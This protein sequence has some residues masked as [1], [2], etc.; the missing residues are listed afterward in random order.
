MRPRVVHVP[1]HLLSTSNAKTLKGE[2]LGYSTAILHLAP[3]TRSGVANVCAYATPGCI[4]ACLDSTGRLRQVQ[5]LNARMQRTQFLKFDRHG[6]V[7]MLVQEI[8]AHERRAARAGFAPA[9]R[10]NGLS[11]IPWENMPAAG[12]R[13][14][15]AAFPEC[16]FYDYTKFPIRL[17]RRAL[18][19]PNY[20]LTFSLSDGNEQ[21]ARQALAAGVN[22]AAIFPPTGELPATFWGLPVINGDES[23]LRFN[24]PSPCIVG[25]RAKGTR[26]RKTSGFVQRQEEHDGAED[27]HGDVH[28]RKPARARGVRP[29]AHQRVRRRLHGHAGAEQRL[30]LR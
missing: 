11:D 25:L 6:F 21:H 19:E 16:A 8:A 22:V 18:A 28:R 27:L 10:L 2:A 20:S 26:W 7:E 5:A 23:D 1:R 3:Y 4:E 17:R 12:Y 24:D 30:R 13:N 14:V 9:V 15:M 29:R